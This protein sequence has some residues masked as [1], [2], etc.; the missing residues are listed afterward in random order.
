MRSNFHPWL[1]VAG[2]VLGGCGSSGAGAQDGG[3]AAPGKCDSGATTACS[4]FTTPTGTTIQLG[5]YAAE[6]DP[7]VGAGFENK[8]QTGDTQGSTYCNMF[9]SI[10]AQSPALTA[11][12]LGTSQNGVK[13]DFALYTVYRPATW[14]SHPV[15][16]ITWGNGTCAQPEGYGALLRYVASY[17]FFVVA[18]NSREVGMGTPP[19]MLHA[20]DYAAAANK[21]PKSP[22]YQK[23]DMTK[24]GAMGHSQG[25]AATATAASDS[26][27]QDVILFNAIGSSLG[28]VPKPFLAISGD[29]DIAG[30]TPSSMASAVDAAT[31][32]AAWLYFHMVPTTGN[33][34]GH[35]TLM[36]QPQRVTE[37]TRDWW[38]MM[39]QSD[40]SARSEFAGSSCGL[41][42]AAADHE[43]GAHGL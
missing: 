8:I 4:S 16:V 34:S 41:C 17:G 23:L 18:A 3:I 10:F 31:V 1:A 38:Q 42:N 13:L 11:Q 43:Y 15:P 29:N 39:F 21:D 40:A 20:L 28:S 14:P 12:L 6:M 25:G 2:V 27:I 30:F 22:Y 33:F 5:P 7:N 24:V 36:M 37:A 9:T 32:P 26:R 35:L 19:P